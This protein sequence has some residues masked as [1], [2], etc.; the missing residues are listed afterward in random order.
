MLSMQGSLTCHEFDI[1]NGTIIRDLQY[2]IPAS[3][4]WN[5][6]SI[7]LTKNIISGIDG[8]GRFVGYNYKYGL[9]TGYGENS[10]DNHKTISSSDDIVCTTVKYDKNDIERQN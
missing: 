9:G 4:K 5:P 10:I 2:L 7:K 6:T 1:E 3:L 8:K